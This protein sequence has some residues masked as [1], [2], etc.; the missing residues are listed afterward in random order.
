MP[1]SLSSLLGSLPTWNGGGSECL[2]R[3]S[4]G[5]LVHLK[6]SPNDFDWEK[7]AL[8]YAKKLKE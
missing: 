2:N 1:E 4:R 6:I 8:E 7:V 3:M 5:G